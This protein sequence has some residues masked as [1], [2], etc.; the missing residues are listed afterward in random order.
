MFVQENV[1]WFL[2]F[3]YIRDIEN[4]LYSEIYMFYICVL[5]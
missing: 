1:I 4:Q 5:F 2:V 3:Q